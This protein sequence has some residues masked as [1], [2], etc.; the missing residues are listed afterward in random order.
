MFSIQFWFDYTEVSTRNQ[1]KP[2]WIIRGVPKRKQ[3]IEWKQFVFELLFL[4]VFRKT[5]KRINT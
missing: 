4:L 3:Q 2:K 1:P 5:P